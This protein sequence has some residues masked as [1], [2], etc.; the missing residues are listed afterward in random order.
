MSSNVAQPVDQAPGDEG[1]RV[2]LLLLAQA[3]QGRWTGRRHR[4]EGAVV[5]V[6]DRRVEREEV[7]RASHETG[8]PWMAT[9]P[10]GPGPTTARHR[11]CSWPEPISALRRQ[12]WCDGIY[13]RG[14]AWLYT[15]RRRSRDTCV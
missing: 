3:L 13:A 6:G 5:E 4:A 9:P 10:S 8:T 12:D 1:D 15:W 7:A 11:P 14:W 2:A